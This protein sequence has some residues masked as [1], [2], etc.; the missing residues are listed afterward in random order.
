[1]PL[2]TAPER[3]RAVASPARVPD[4]FRSPRRPVESPGRRGPR[5]P[6]RRTA[7]VCGAVVV[8]SLL[9]V[10]ASSAYLTQG[11]VRLTRVQQQLNSALGQHSDLEARVAQLADPSTVISQAQL[12]GLTAP[13]K[14]TDLPQVTTPKTS[15]AASTT[16]PAGRSP[17]GSTGGR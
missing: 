9:M 11:Q 6:L 14:E 13:T 15:T 17:V 8:A 1:M 2:A 7:A 10:V 4:G 12:H 16:P 3:Q 5:W